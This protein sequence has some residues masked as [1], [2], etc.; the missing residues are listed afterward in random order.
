MRRLYLQIFLAFI[1][2]AFTSGVAAVIATHLFQD[3][4]PPFIEVYSRTASFIVQDLPLHPADTAD[5]QTALRSALQKR[6]SRLGLEIAVWDRDGKLLAATGKAKRL[7]LP[8]HHNEQ[9]RGFFGHS[10]FVVQLPEGQWISIAPSSHDRAAGVINLFVV[11]AVLLS[12]TSLGCYWLA[13]RITRRLEALR[14]G[15]EKLG[16]GELSTRVP[17]QGNDEVAVLAQSFNQAADRIDALIKQQKRILTSASHELRSPLT[18]LRMA[19]ELIADDARKSKEQKDKLFEDA[20]EEIQEL[21]AL[22]GDVLLAA[23]LEDAAQPKDFSAVDLHQLILQEATR[24][25]A[26]FESRP[27]QVWGERR[28]LRRLV[29]NLLENARRYGHGSRVEISLESAHDPVCSDSG[30]TIVVADRG[31]G[32]PEA[33]RERIF[34][35]FYRP[36]GHREGEHGGVGLGLYLVRQIAEFHRGTVRHQPREGGGSRFEVAL[37]GPLEPKVESNC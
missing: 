13:R 31:P 36:Q 5:G 9:S 37:P 18:R 4:D 22:I 19:L 7:S 16:A 32:I 15:V 11:I 17:V 21:D 30:V 27:M 14:N 1:A 12:V 6:A 2:I 20:S 23:R 8:K 34:E 25:A 24:A 28:M 29:R 33:D 10:G 26:E 35:P 3:H